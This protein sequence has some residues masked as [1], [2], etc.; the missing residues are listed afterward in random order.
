[1]Q[2]VAV[3]VQ[4]TYP[5]QS[6]QW[7]GAAALDWRLLVGTQPRRLLLCGNLPC[8][9]TVAG[10]CGLNKAI[11]WMLE[12]R[13]R[14][15]IFVVEAA[16]IEASIDC[17]MEVTVRGVT[18]RHVRQVVNIEGVGD[19]ATLPKAPWSDALSSVHR[20]SRPSRCCVPGCDAPRH[21]GLDCVAHYMSG[22]TAS[23]AAEIESEDE[24]LLA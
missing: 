23:L 18:M 13:G 22:P 15:C 3:E 11:R 7:H 6:V 10:A 21:V 24:P 5:D 9:I 12:R 1:M 19:A 4:N 17:T 2:V 8:W 14:Y 20:L 16:V